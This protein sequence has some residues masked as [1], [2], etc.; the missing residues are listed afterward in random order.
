MLP[1]KS[2]RQAREFTQNRNEYHQVLAEELKEFFDLTGKKEIKVR[3]GDSLWQLARDYHAPLWL[4]YRMNPA[5]KQSLKPGQTIVV[6]ILQ[7]K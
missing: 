3:Q 2:A 4:L 6:P 7:A 5:L 1:I